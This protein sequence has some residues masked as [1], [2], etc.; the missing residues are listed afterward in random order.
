MSHEYVLTAIAKF[1]VIENAAICGVDLHHQS[2]DLI[3]GDF[4]ADGS[5]VHI[6]VMNVCQRHRAIQCFDVKMSAINVMQINISRSFFKVYITLDSFRLQG[7][8]GGM[9]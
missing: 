4:A 8:C 6:T 3:H 5:D 1:S 7:T 2:I 9:Q